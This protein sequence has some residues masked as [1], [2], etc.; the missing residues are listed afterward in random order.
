MDFGA[1][2]WPSLLTILVATLFGVGG[3]KGADALTAYRQRM[4]GQNPNDPNAAGAQAPVPVVLAPGSAAPP[5]RGDVTGSIRTIS[6]EECRSNH[7][8]IEGQLEK[9]A[10]AHVEQ[11]DSLHEIET[12]I[13]KLHGEI[14]ERFARLE[15]K[16]G[17]T[18]RAEIATHERQHHR[19]AAR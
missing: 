18:V 5:A 3:V 12:G 2:D 15:L 4:A 8:H 9:I 1:I 14:G 10:E 16:V 19:A 17:D 13:A 7:S 6:A 11:R